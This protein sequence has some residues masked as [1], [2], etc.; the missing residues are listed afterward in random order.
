MYTNGERDLASTKKYN[1][2]LLH[3]IIYYYMT[4]IKSK[5]NEWLT[6]VENQICEIAG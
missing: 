5:W 1:I 6:Y 3:Y 2:D 4:M